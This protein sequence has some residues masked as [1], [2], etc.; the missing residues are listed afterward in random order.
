MKAALTLAIALGLLT[1]LP[2]SAQF[3]KPEDAVKYRQAAFGLM[4]AHMKRLGAMAKGEV[5]F[6]AK[7][8]ADNA[9]VVAFMSKLPFHAF[10]EGSNIA[11]SKAEAKVWSEAD[12]FKAAAGKFQEEAAKLSAAAKT[13]NLDALKAAMG[14]TGKSCKACHDNYK[15]D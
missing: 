13:G 2:A 7:A 5:P 11:P 8:A 9:E 12:K 6:D 1:S 3:A 15:K 14:A 10:V 4:A